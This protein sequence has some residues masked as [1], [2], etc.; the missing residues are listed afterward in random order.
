MRTLILDARER[1]KKIVV[2]K[3]DDRVLTEVTGDKDLMS[4]VDQIFKKT[5]SHISQIRRIE[6]RSDSGSYT[7]I[8][9]SL[10]IAMALSYALGLPEPVEGG[11]P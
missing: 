2:L 5:G 9:L 8:R 11:A 10:S 7:G 3:E 1:Y 4:L 6:V